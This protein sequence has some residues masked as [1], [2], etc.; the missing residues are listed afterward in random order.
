MSDGKMKV[1]AGESLE[2]T[3]FCTD[4]SPNEKKLVSCG[5]LRNENSDADLIQVIEESLLANA[6]GRRYVLENLPV[7]QTVN[8]INDIDDR[9]S[10]HYM[11]LFGNY[12]PEIF[13]TILLGLTGRMILCHL[14]NENQKEL[15]AEIEKFFEKLQELYLQENFNKFKSKLLHNIVQ[16]SNCFGRE[17]GS[18][19]I[20]WGIL[21]KYY[22]N[23]ETLLCKYD[24]RQG[25]Y[26]YITAS[27]SDREIE[28]IHN[29]FLKIS[30]IT[31]INLGTA[32]KK[33]FKKKE[34]S[35]L[36]IIHMIY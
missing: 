25:P 9:D 15:E 27:E 32:Y 1:A 16:Y 5:K 31:G 24:E 23:A 30:E 8:M 4:R 20:C 19:H 34:K 22:S 12:A 3:M 7:I 10:I 36:H 26:N 13:K 2:Q 11:C 33:F 6:T 18:M 29:I 28:H 14:N 35:N 21:R 17:T